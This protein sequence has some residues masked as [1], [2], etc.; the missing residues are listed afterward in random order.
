[1]HKKC[2]FGDGSFLRV[3]REFW[4]TSVILKNQILYKGGKIAKKSKTTESIKGLSCNF[5]RNG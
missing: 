5:K 1:M 2:G 4:D 3:F